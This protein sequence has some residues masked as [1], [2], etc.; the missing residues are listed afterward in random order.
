MN[1]A[2]ISIAAGLALIFILALPYSL[3]FSAVAALFLLV[4]QK[5]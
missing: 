5:K 1:L 3:V 4:R 2:G